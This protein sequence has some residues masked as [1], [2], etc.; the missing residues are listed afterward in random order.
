MPNQ[1]NGSDQINGHFA[2]YEKIRLSSR[3]LYYID[4]ECGG[5]NQSVRNLEFV[6]VN[7]HLLFVDCRLK[8]AAG[9]K[10]L[11]GHTNE[12][13]ARPEII[14]TCE[15]KVQVALGFGLANAIVVRKSADSSDGCVLIDTLESNEGAEQ[16]LQAFKDAGIIG[17]TMT[18]HCLQHFQILAHQG[19]P[20]FWRIHQSPFFGIFGVCMCGPEENFAQGGR[21]PFWFERFIKL[22]N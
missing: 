4:F 12:F 13:G 5:A 16:V 15:G 8:N 18:L 19:G 7:Y 22:L 1:N 9:E 10:I 11:A 14:S 2:Y 21:F 20:I 3:Q 17:K 6:L